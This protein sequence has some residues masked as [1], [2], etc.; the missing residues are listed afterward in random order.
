[1]GRKPKRREGVVVKKAIKR[2]RYQEEGTDVRIQESKKPRVPVER[3][4]IVLHNARGFDEVTEHDTMDLIR[5]Q[6][7][8]IVGI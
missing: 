5:N 6:K 8:E 1:M 7:P 2:G 4:K 3:I